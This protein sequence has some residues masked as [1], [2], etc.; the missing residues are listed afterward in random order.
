MDDFLGE[1]AQC[2]STPNNNLGIEYLRA[3]RH[4]GSSMMP[5]T[6]LRLGAAHDSH[7]DGF[8]SHVSASY[9][10]E[11]VLTGDPSSLSPY[12]SDWQEEGL[13]ADP[14]SLSFCERAVLARLRIMEEEDFAL[15]PDSGEGL[16]QRLYAASRQASSLEEVY[17]ITKTK[18]YT[19]ARIRRMVLW[20]FLGLST[21]SIPETPPYIRVLGF[22]SRGQELLKEMKK[23]ASLP[24]IVKPAHAAKLSAEARAVFEL[25]ARSTG[26]YDLCRKQFGILP[27]K[28]EYT[29]NPVRL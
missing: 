7:E 17:S 3:L 13:R 16:S 9:L 23:T 18:R 20:S 12:L 8:S 29:Q 26:V 4:T 28:N 10:R 25:E 5:H 1:A 6:I 14:T 11:K 15:L 27:G 24:V 19:H 21:D 22:T 2:M